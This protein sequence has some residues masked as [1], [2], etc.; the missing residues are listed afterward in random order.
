MA[1]S[2]W[3]PWWMQQDGPGSSGC[4]LAARLTSRVTRC[5]GSQNCLARRS[6]MRA[7]A[8]P[9]GGPQSVNKMGSHTTSSV[10]LRA[11]YRARSCAAAEAPRRQPGHVGERSRTRRG[12]A[13]PASKAA[14]N[15][16]KL[17]GESR[18]SGRWPA[19]AEDGPQELR[20]KSR[21]RRAPA[22]R[23]AAW[24]GRRPRLRLPAPRRSRAAGSS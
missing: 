22:A 1:S 4:R 10:S 9:L 19:G 6:G 14:L 17:A 3:N 2:Q 21:L 24:S 23:D 15:S 16:P 20:A 11:G 8:L 5:P 18:A 12:A 13:A 7:S